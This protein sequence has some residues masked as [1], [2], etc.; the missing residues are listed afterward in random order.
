[1]GKCII[2]RPDGYVHHYVGNE[3]SSCFQ[4]PPIPLAEF[5]AVLAA[6]SD[7]FTAHQ[8]HIEVTSTEVDLHRHAGWTTVL[9]TAGRGIFRDEAG[10]HP[11]FTGDRVIIPPN[12]LHLSIAAP[13]T[14]MIED[15]IY[16]GGRNDRQDYAIRFSI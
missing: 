14:I 12:T 7:E 6:Q 9:I 8:V 2:I 5:A 11:V 1:M 10:D 15:G 16:F 13:H 4:Y 3:K